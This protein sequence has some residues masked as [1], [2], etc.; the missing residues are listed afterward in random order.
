MKLLIMQSS[1]LPSYLSPLHNACGEDHD[2]FIMQ[3]SPLPTYL[4]PLHNNAFSADHGAPH[5][6]A[7]SI[8][9]LAP[10][11]NTTM[12]EME[13]IKLSLCSFLHSHISFL[14]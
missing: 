5:D 14:P 1:P 10:S 11:L 13:N 6:V 9:L 7:F 8:P 4:S 3:S 12:P 2:A